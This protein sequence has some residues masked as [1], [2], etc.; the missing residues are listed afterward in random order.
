MMND[1]PHDAE[2][3]AMVARTREAPRDEFASRLKERFV[4]GRFDEVAAARRRAPRWPW[5]AGL[6]AAAVLAIVLWPDDPQL[7]P[8]ADD[9]LP[10]ASH[11]DGLGGV[12]ALPPLEVL[13]D[14]RARALSRHPGVDIDA[15]LAA[16]LAGDEVSSGL[17]T[18]DLVSS[19]GLT[20]RLQPR[21]RIVADASDVDGERLQ[22]RV[23]DGELLIR[24]PR[25]YAG[26]PMTFATGQA[27]VDVVGTALSIMADVTG[28]CVCVSHGVVEVTDVT[29][30]A[31]T[32]DAPHRVT[33][34][35]TCFVFGAELP[36]YL[37]PSRGL[38]GEYEPVHREPLM[39]FDGR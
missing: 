6:A 7:A 1:E 33:A 17:V 26:A 5:A 27:S 16:F 23:L 13:P 25:D 28:T 11:D 2:I 32:G 14:W 12:E 37:G 22:L 29:A 31:E 34:D 20:L 9:P 21:T 8:V 15:R 36:T 38:L 18:F 35:E 3:E 39:R 24:T 10:V 4:E 19:D 30:D